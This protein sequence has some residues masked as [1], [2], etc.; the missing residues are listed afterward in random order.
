[1][2][3]DRALFAELAASGGHGCGREVARRRRAEAEVAAWP[4][5]ALSDLD[6]PADFQRIKLQLEGR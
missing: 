2:L 4:R 6:V 3:F 5:S 1:M